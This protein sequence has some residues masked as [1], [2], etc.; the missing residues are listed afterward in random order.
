MDDL[1]IRY[2]PDVESPAMVMGLTGWMDGGSVST[3]TVGYLIDRLGAAEF[4]EIKSHDFYIFHFPISTIPLSIR[5]DDDRAV[6]TSVNPMEVAAIFR[7][8]AKIENGIVNEL[9]YPRNRF[10]CAEK[11]K[12]VLFLGE[13]PHLRW[14]TYLECLFRVAEEMGIRE[15][16]FV[17]SVAGALPHTREPRLKASVASEQHKERLAG[18]DIGYSDYEGPASLITALSYQSVERGIA[19]R[20]LVAEVPHYP[21]VEMPAY[22]RSILKTTSALNDLLNL[23]LDLSDLIRAAEAVE[24]KLNGLAEENEAFRELVAK[25]E[26]VYDQEEIDPDAG[27]LKRLMD[28]IDLGDV[29]RNG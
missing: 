4:A 29:E 20:S 26:A 22:P 28:G 16:Y 24:A 2:R 14:G 10:F 12:L 15:V 27:L 18:L 9:T 3:G 19:V 17:G 11:Q 13:E 6:M 25:L 8:H 1:Q 5:M 7:P 21:F 23:H